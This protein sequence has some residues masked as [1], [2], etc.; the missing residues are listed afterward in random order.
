M[1]TILEAD[2]ESQARV[3]DSLTR[4]GHRVSLG[5]L[6]Q[7]LRGDAAGITLPLSTPLDPN[8]HHA[9]LT[10]RRKGFLE[11]RRMKI[12]LRR[13]HG[14]ER[15]VDAP[16]LLFARQGGSLHGISQSASQRDADQWLKSWMLYLW[17][18]DS[19][20]AYGAVRWCCPAQPEWP[21]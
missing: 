1:I 19:V 4:D 8:V 18:A 13:L 14:N 10:K 2:R 5:S 15:T 7:D 16:M 12:K 17:L 3:M 9:D 11:G 6:A 20:G 21:S